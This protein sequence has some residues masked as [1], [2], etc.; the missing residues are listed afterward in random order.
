MNP[1]RVLSPAMRQQ[2]NQPRFIAPM[3]LTSGALPS[4]DAWTFEVKWDG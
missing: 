4:G 2:E 1:G 3:L